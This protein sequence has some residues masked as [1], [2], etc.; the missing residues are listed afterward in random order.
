[1]LPENGDGVASGI[2]VKEAVLPFNR[3][4]RV[5]GE[6]VDTVLGPEM[7]STGEVMGIA[8]TFGA[9]LAEADVEAES[10]SGGG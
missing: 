9:A 8:S 1:M 7:K 2:S 6:G 3:F 4:R 5:D 10:I